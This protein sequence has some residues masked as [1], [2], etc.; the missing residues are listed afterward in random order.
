VSGYLVHCALE[1]CSQ[2][3]CAAQ[4]RGHGEAVRFLRSFG[5]PL[6]V[7]GGGGYIKSNVARCWAYET[8][9]L[10]GQPVAEALPRTEYHEYYAPDFSLN[11][12]GSKAMEDLNAKQHYVE[13]LRREVLEHLRQLQA[14]PS[15]QMQELPPT[16]RLPL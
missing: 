3:C 14:A 15:V 6:L 10:T 16:N 2:H 9:L 4:V 12:S 13:G 5:I 8:S 1:Q 11:L 7:T